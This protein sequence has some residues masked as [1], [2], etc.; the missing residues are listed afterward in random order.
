M[1]PRSLGVCASAT[2]GPARW[3]LVGR[4]HRATFLCVERNN[5]FALFFFPGDVVRPASSPGTVIRVVSSTNKKT[6]VTL[7]GRY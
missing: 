4:V 6:I 7:V 2:P 1:T 3:A 5:P